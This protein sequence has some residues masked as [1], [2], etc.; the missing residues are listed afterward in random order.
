VSLGPA[1]IIVVLVI[2]LLVFG[3]TRLPEVGRQVGRTMREFKKFQETIRTDVT[4]VFHDDEPA[5]ATK[6]AEPPPSLPPK[7]SADTTSGD[8]TSGDTTSGDSTSGASA[9]IE[10]LPTDPSPTE[11]KEAPSM[12]EPSATEKGD[13][14]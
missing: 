11:P 2:A 7:A 4:S 12:S 8:T 5:D 1:E 3:P 13:G 14:A 9:G 6:A 10:A